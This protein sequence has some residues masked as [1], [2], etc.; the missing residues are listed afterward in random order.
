MPYMI[1]NAK[2][3]TM[4]ELSPAAGAYE[5]HDENVKGLIAP[6]FL[7]DFTVL[8]TDL[9]DCDESAILSAKPVMTA[10]GGE[11]VYGG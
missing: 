10:V 6:G 9:L 5:T 3:A 7:A 11:I 4:N 2:I 1:K 8:D